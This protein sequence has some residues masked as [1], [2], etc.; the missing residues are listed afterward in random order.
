MDGEYGH[1]TAGIPVVNPKYQ[2][3]GAAGTKLERPVP[4]T[5]LL[6][7]AFRGSQGGSMDGGCLSRFWVNF[8]NC[9]AGARKLARTCRN[10]SYLYFRKRSKKD[11]RGNTG[12]HASGLWS[13]R[14]LGFIG[15]DYP[16][17][18]DCACKGGD[19]K[20]KRRQ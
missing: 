2:T 7:E 4:V 10:C 16:A 8:M 18:D 1:I 11:P 14:K 15:R 3:L 19:F 5:D 20:R 12:S 9:A 17:K 6:R 13:C